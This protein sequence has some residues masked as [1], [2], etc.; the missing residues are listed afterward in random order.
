MIRQMVGF[1]Q[2]N[3]EKPGEPIG[4]QKEVRKN[5]E[6]RKRISKFKCNF[7]AWFPGVAI[8]Y[9]RR[10]NAHRALWLP[11][12]IYPLRYR[13][14]HGNWCVPTTQ[15]APRTLSLWLQLWLGVDV[16]QLERREVGAGAEVRGD[17]RTCVVASV[18]DSV[19]E[20]RQVRSC[21]R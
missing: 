17:L 18:K 9:R 20:D 11:P 14:C 16:A 3:P 13:G 10:G 8:H 1:L 12:S 21:H 4:S 6:R 19:G 15:V 2:L 7:S 5:R